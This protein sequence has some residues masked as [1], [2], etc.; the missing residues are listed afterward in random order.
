M[1]KTMATKLT[2]PDVLRYLL[3][4]MCL[5]LV[6]LPTGW[7]MLQILSDVSFTWVIMGGNPRV[8]RV[9]YYILVSL[10]VVLWVSGVIFAETWFREGV[11]EIRMR[12]ARAELGSPAPA[13]ALPDNKLLRLL[14][15][16][17]LDTLA[18]RVL[19]ALGI[20]LFLVV[21]RFLG[22]QALFSI[23]AQSIP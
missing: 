15:G 6:V 19:I 7:V 11:D 1:V 10:I 16:W 17:G 13:D 23:A 14:R 2:L 4:Y 9:G 12:R 22:Q 20:L 8:H 3:A 18:R 5:G 21:L